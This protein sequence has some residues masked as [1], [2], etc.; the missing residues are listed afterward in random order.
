MLERMGQRKEINLDTFKVLEPK[1]TPGFEFYH[2][3]RLYPEW[4]FAKLA[5]TS[6]KLAEQV[7]AALL[8][9]S[10]DS[11]AATSGK[12]T[13]WTKPLDYE[14]VNTL[15]EE[16]GVGPYKI[17]DSIK[18]STFIE[19][20]WKTGLIILLTL[21]IAIFIAW[22]MVLS[23]R[24]LKNLTKKLEDYRK[25]LEEQVQ[26]RTADLVASNNELESYSY[27]IA[28]DL[29]SPLRSVVG[30]SQILKKEASEKLNKEEL[31]AID[32][33]VKSGSHMA[34][35]INDILDLSRITRDTLKKDKLD[36]SAICHDLARSFNE[37][38]AE[39]H[40]NW[41]IED[42]VRCQGDKKL[43]NRLLQNLIDN[44]CKFTRD[45]VQ[46][47]I[48]FGQKMIDGVTVYFVRDNGIGFDMQYSEK[49]F[50][51]F[52]RLYRN[53]YDGTGIGLSIAKRVIERHGGK[54]WVEA[55][56]GVGA[57]FYFTLSTLK[58]AD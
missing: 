19:T 53:E 10:S 32:R 22:W 28:H 27:S 37:Q 8:E 50:T 40:I 56:A 17:S 30:F 43:I 45:T 31:D 16:L 1:K 47:T 29:R 25:Q 48:E 24:K 14:P 49:I 52:N 58:P 3:S 33:I 5:H 34:E 41:V 46:P 44:A 36:L 11:Q 20:Y 4:P 55:K 12:Y 2:S 21:L 54:I 51:P 26:I 18:L 35:V 42:D 39:R 6:E 7:T 38:Y 13:G 9:I 15:L 23:N 57:T